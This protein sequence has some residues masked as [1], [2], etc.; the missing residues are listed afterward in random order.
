MHAQQMKTPPTLLSI[1]LE[2]RFSIYWELLNASIPNF[3]FSGSS[4]EH[5][6]PPRIAQDRFTYEQSDGVYY[7][8]SPLFGTTLPLQ[9]TCKQFYT[10]IELFNATDSSRG[11]SCHLELAILRANDIYLTWLS[12]P[13]PPSSPLS[14]Y[15]VQVD[16]RSIRP[17]TDKE[18]RRGIFRG[19]DG[20]PPRIAWK[21]LAILNRFLRRGPTF[22]SAAG[23]KD[24]PVKVENITLNFITSTPSNENLDDESGEKAEIRYQKHR[25]NEDGTYKAEDAL[26][27]VKD[28]FMIALRQRSTSY[29]DVPKFIFEKLQRMEFALDGKVDSSIDVHGLKKHANEAGAD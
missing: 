21:L 4:Q 15:H 10:E 23:N 8:R 26:R 14:I 11:I 6:S 24:T 19:G 7:P 25:R 29:S 20:G 17:V 22:T 2:L 5:L 27:L 3:P 1:P 18:F 12:L 9:L 16:F 28:L 13:P